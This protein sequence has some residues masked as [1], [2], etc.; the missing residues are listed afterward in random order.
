MMEQWV[1]RF[2]QYPIP[3]PLH[4][5]ITP[6]LHGRAPWLV[7]FLENVEPCRN[8][9]Q[10][11]LRHPNNHGLPLLPSG[12]GGVHPHLSH[13]AQPSTLPHGP[14]FPEPTASPRDST[15]LERVAGHPDN[16][17][18]QGT[19]N[20]PSSTADVKVMGGRRMVN[21]EWRWLIGGMGQR[22]MACH[23][24]DPARRTCHK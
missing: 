20:S 3:P 15:L 12:P 22:A 4:Y 11:D 23:G 2:T 13:R 8:S 18:N 17:G 9:G 14:P 6:I 10:V 1:C 21:G 7:D 16:V 24:I 5:S 19:A